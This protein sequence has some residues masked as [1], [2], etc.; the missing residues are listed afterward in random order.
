MIIKPRIFPGFYFLSF[1]YAC[2]LI[3]FA[4]YL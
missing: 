2:R 3:K 4:D 1:V